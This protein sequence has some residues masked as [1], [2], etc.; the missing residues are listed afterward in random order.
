MVRNVAAEAKKKIRAIKVAVQP[1]IRSRYNRT[2]MGIL[3]GDPSIQ[4]YGLCSS[5]HGGYNNAMVSEVQF[6]VK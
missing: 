4:M 6:L 2:F 3:G 1:A 5:F